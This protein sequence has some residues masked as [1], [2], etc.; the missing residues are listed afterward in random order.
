MS[1]A[2]AQSQISDYLDR[3][4]AAL[5]DL[6]AV[7][8]DELLEDLP[9]HLAEVLAEDAGTLTERLGEPEAYA[10]E[11][12]AAAGIAV[13]GAAAATGSTRPVRRWLRGAATRADARFGPALGYRRASELLVQLRPGWWVLRG[14]LAGLL[15]Y[16]MIFGSPPALPPPHPT[17]LVWLMLVLLGILGSVRLGQVT[18]SQIGRVVLAVATVFLLVFAVAVLNPG[19]ERFETTA[20]LADVYLSDGPNRFDGVVDVYPYDA[21]GHPLSGVRLYD[22]NGQPIVLGDP[23]RC[24]TP[25]AKP[26]VFDRSGPDKFGSAFSHGYPLCPPTGWAPSGPAGSQPS[27]GPSPQPVPQPSPTR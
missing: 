27:S 1:T 11:L 24:L 6:P 10:A 15:V 16:A 8:R 18:L 13:A 7:A 26:R 3:V 4:R 2:P 23:F 12:R 19:R 22:Q 5:A 21:N 25:Q 17:A 14:Y 20:G 9:D